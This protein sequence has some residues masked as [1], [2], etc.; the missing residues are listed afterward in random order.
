[1]FKDLSFKIES[2]EEVALVGHNGAGKTTIVKLLA[3]I[4]PAT[5]G[6]ILINGF[7]ITALAIDD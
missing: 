3:R 6:Q 4:Y 7:D 2:G 1:M 5:K